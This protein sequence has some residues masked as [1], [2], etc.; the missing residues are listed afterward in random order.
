M[1]LFL[2][3]IVALVPVVLL[4]Q[5]T[6]VVHYLPLERSPDVLADAA[7]Q[8]VTRLGHAETVADAAWGFTPTDFL[9]YLR[10]TD[11]TSTRYERLRSGQPPGVTFWYRQ[12]PAALSTD[13]FLLGGVVTLNDPSAR[14]AGMVNVMLDLK[15]RLHFLQAV[16]S[17]LEEPE[18]R[19]P[20][21]D[22]P[23]LFRE[24]GF[25][26]RRSR[27]SP[28]RWVPPVFADT[29]AA[30]T[31]A[32]PDRPDIAIRV[33]AAAW[34]GTPVYF[35]IFEPWSANTLGGP[36][37][38][39]RV[40]AAAV[41]PFVLLGAIFTGAFLLARRNLR[42]SRGDQIGALRLALI[43][44]LM[45]VVAG[46]MTA[47]LTYE[48]IPTMRTLGLLMGRG[49]LLGMMVY[50]IYMALEPDVRRRSPETLIAWSRVLA[51]RLKDPLVGRDLLLG[52]LLG[53]VHHLLE[54]LAQRAPAW[55]G[56]APRVSVPFLGFDGSPRQHDL[57]RPEQQRRRSADRHHAAAGVRPVVRR[58]SASGSCNR[59]VRRAARPVDRLSDRLVAVARVPA[60]R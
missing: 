36:G 34:R 13:S 28:P 3:V 25:D 8:I 46:L 45:H 44:C 10:E 43:L 6:Q 11:Q 5:K 53:V 4:S 52:I 27:R 37:G 60:G 15:G 22:W 7:H 40:T 39:Q 42:L 31:G 9:N 2:A 54:Q 21:P 38:P 23:A 55:V 26:P 19:Q 56:R 47:H 30:W 41:L 35:Q 29:R 49:L 12:S 24:A 58:R 18:A 51:G 33:E 16:P 50:A 32:Y 1:L 20:A 14:V 48:L 59:G 57:G 17:R